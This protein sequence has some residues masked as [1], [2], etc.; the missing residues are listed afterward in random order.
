MPFV[1]HERITASSSAWVA[2]C[3]SQSLIQRPPWPCCRHFRLDGRIRDHSAKALGNWLAGQFFKGRLGI[4]QIDV[5]R[6]TL[7]EQKDHALGP[8]GNMRW[9]GSQR[10]AA[11]GSPKG[12]GSGLTVSEPGECDRPKAGPGSGEHFTA[13][14]KSHGLFLVEPQRA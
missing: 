8:A 10:I 11:A 4:E 5:A 2:M 7:H 1:Q 12:G 13:R 3:G 14:E 6:P 9:L